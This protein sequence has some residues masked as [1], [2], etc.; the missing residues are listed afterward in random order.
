[1]RTDQR[2]RAA[3]P[4]PPPYESGAV[5][6]GASGTALS[7]GARPCGMTRPCGRSA[8]HR[9][10]RPDPPRPADRRR[11]VGGRTYSVATRIICS[12]GHLR[13]RVSGACAERQSLIRHC[14]Y[15]RRP[16]DLAAG[17]HLEVPSSGPRLV[18]QF[19]DSDTGCGLAFVAAINRAEARF[20]GLPDIV[21][22][23]ECPGFPDPS[24]SAP[25]RAPTVAA[26]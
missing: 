19:P 12:A 22:R 5:M 4:R 13:R 7:N 20:T 17:Q 18:A 16:F 24:R 11:Q 2:A 10:I 23:V 14:R 26:T 6:R 9:Q 15:H 3:R 25:D 1:M 21:R 8:H